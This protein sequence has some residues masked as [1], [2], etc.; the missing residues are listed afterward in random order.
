MTMEGRASL[1]TDLGNGTV[2]RRG[3]QPQREARLMELAGS[4]GFPVPRVHEVRAD[5]L[6]MERIDGPT[7]AGA[8]RRRPW[9]LSRHVAILAD[10]HERL[11]RIPLEG[12]SLLHRDLHPE[13]VLV[14]PSGPLVIDWTNAGPGDGAV[15]LALTWLILATSGGAPG[16]LM[17]ALFRRKVGIAALTA[18]LQEARAY[19]LADPN[20]TDAERRRARSLTV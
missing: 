17:A 4:H 13:N 16:R 3:G 12:A 8:I 19:R 10:L 1:V 15:D 5:G 9:H 18:G 7:M 20:V 6:V 2:L 14:S 11:H